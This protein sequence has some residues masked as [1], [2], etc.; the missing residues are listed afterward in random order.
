M[1]HYAMLALIAVAAYFV[2]AKFPAL[3]KKTGLV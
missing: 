3:A 2:G 1:K